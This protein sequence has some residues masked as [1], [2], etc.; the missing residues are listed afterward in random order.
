MTRTVDQLVAAGLVSREIPPADRRQVLLRVTPEGRAADL[1][2]LRAVYRI[3][4]RALDG[5]EEEDRRHFARLQQAML[6]NLVADQAL[7]RRLVE[8][9]RDGDD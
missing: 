2:A 3:N 6:S 5:I 7:V 4:R 9:A 1:Q 8:H